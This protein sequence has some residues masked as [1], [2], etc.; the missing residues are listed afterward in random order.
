MGDGVVLV[1]VALH[2]AKGQAEHHFA[3]GCYTI[4]NR[5]HPELLLIHA[6]LGVD[7]RVS[8]KAGRNALV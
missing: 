3:G 7:L 4:N 8:V 2:T 1:F 6:A 5:I